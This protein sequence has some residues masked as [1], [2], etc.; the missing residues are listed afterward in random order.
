MRKR[1]ILLALLAPLGVILYLD[2]I[3]IG[4][5]LPRI[6]DDLHIAPER[7][8]WISLAFSL[9]YAGFE[10]PAGHLGD[11]RGPR[12]VLTRIVLGWS[13][14]TALT[15]A[16]TGLWSLLV[17]RLFF[18]ASEAGA[19]PNVS[20]AMA[21]WFP[22][23]A[24]A[25]T[26]GAFLSATQLGGAIT[27]L[28]VVPIQQRWGWRVPF[29]A[30][31]L[32]GAAWA[33]AWY[34]WF[35]DTPAEKSGVRQEELDELGPPLARVAHGL[36]W[37]VGIRSG[38][39]WALSAAFF[40]S[41]YAVYFS[42]FWA[43]TFLVR[44]RGFTESQLRWVALVGLVGVVFN[45][46]GGIVS[47]RLIARLGRARGRRLAGGLGLGIVAV[48]YCAAAL[49]SGKVTTLGF[50]MLETAGWG[51]AQATSL[52]VCVDVGRAHSGTVAG[53]M[54]TAGQ[55]GGALSGV[56]FGYLVKAT[57][58]YD[59]PMFV[60]AGVAAVGAACWWGIDASRP[61]LAERAAG[62]GASWP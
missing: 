50:L 44:A 51:L 36:P 32:V 25:K 54:N 26:M 49:A 59:V 45:Y 15:G 9:G 11:R 12:R 22:A 47:D 20:S 16:V 10:V 29:F 7:L 2:R 21:R 38:T 34:A 43:P 6:Q 40:C 53:V 27:P 5:A 52:A 30:F 56:V 61:L 8:G 41:I 14:F 48:G 19:I 31:G 24:R 37:R 33:I 60:M 17:T 57:G 28:L 4:V 23:H 62:A 3:C 42:I 55:I 13:V 58:S 35:R 46:G 18:G 39:L 1:H